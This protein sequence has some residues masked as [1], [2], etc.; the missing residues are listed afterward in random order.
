MGKF[1]KGREG[2]ARTIEGLTAFGHLVLLSCIYQ[3]S[4]DKN[5]DPDSGVE[6]IIYKIIG[7]I[8]LHV[9]CP[10]NLHL[11]VCL[12]NLSLLMIKPKVAGNLNY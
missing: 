10:S 1:I 11:P 7:S 9:N 6:K 4:D 8:I 2:K 12:E 3:C 5:P